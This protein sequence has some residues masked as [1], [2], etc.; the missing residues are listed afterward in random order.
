[1][2][3]EF[4]KQGI[5]YVNTMGAA[6]SQREQQGLLSAMTSRPTFCLRG[7]HSWS[8][9][10]TTCQSLKVQNEQLPQPIPAS[11]AVLKEERNG[12]SQNATLAVPK[13]W[14]GRRKRHRSLGV[15]SEFHLAS[16]SCCGSLRPAQD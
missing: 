15:S 5:S 10:P 12:L 3:Q 4:Q 8:V 6:R 13:L 11:A 2:P 16:P 1:M 14:G 9:V 7:A